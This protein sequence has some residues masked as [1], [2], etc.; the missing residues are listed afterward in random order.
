MDLNNKLTSIAL[1]I[2][3]ISINAYGEIKYHD[4]SGPYFGGMLSSSTTKADSNINYTNDGANPSQGWSNREFHGNVFNSINTMAAEDPEGYGIY[5]FREDITPTN[6]DMPNPSAFLSNLQ[7]RNQTASLNLFIG[8]SKQFNNI[9]VGGEFRAAFGNFGAASE[10]SLNS[11]GSKNGSFSDV[12]GAS[13]TFTN[14]NSALSGITSPML[15][16]VGMEYSAT[17][18]QSSSQINKTEFNNS[19][20]MVGRIGYG[21][22]VSEDWRL[23]TLQQK[24]Q[25]LLMSQ[26]LAI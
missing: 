3:S 20:S 6:S 21:F 22:T 5:R 17:Y 12:E 18:Q 11:S 19:N 14:Y 16:F 26:Y 1:A 9:V 10:S 24:H 4:W 23:L 2:S 8:N 25:L 13:V 15:G 7:D